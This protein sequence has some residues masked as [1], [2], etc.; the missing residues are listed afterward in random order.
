MKEIKSDYHLRSKNN[1]KIDDTRNIVWA[2]LEQI[3]K[4]LYCLFNDV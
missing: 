4:N 2:C 1:L 3:K